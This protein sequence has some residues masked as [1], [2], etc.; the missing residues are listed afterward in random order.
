M[1]EDRAQAHSEHACVVRVHVRAYV[2]A[3]M[4]AQ[5]HKR[6]CVRGRCV[7]SYVGAYVTTL[8]RASLY[9]CER[10]CMQKVHRRTA[11]MHAC[12]SV[13]FRTCVGACM[14]TWVLAY[15]ASCMS[16]R[17]R[18]RLCEGMCVHFFGCVRDHVGGAGMYGC[19]RQRACVRVLE[20]TWV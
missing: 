15:V 10:V 17:V 12:V 13:H 1:R 3:C 20:R 7:H 19:V 2:A 4:S 11:C 9:G 8:G 6:A 14:R 5:A 16:A 18:K